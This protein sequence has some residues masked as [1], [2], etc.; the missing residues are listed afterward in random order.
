MLMRIR[1][2]SKQLRGLRGVDIQAN[3]VLDNGEINNL[4]IVVGYVKDGVNMNLNGLLKSQEIGIVIQLLFILVIKILQ[5]YT[6]EN[7]KWD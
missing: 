3:N 4:K 1:V 5:D 2:N 7:Q 6:L